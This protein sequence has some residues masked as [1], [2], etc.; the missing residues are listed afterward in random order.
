MWGGVGSPVL[1]S[2]GE[3]EQLAVVRLPPKGGAR[4]CGLAGEGRIGEKTKDLGIHSAS[5]ICEPPPQPW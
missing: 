5:L 4:H 1:A 3:G 2:C